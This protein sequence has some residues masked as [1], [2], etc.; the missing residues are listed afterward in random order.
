VDHVRAIH[1]P[2]DST[3]AERTSA[4]TS[5]AGVRHGVDILNHV[6]WIA[7][8]AVALGHLRNILLVEYQQVAHPGLFTRLFY[9]LTGFGHF[10]VI[11]FFVLSGYLVGGKVLSLLHTRDIDREWR[12]FLVDRFARIF[13]VLVPALLLSGLV[14]LCAASVFDSQL[15]LVD[16]W[17]RG[18]VAPIPHDLHAP[19]WIGNLLLLNGIFV[20]TVNVD[21]ALW[22]LAYEWFYYMAAA[23][24]VVVYRRLWRPHTI[25]F[26]LYVLVLAAGVVV[27][28]PNVLIAGGSWVAGVVARHIADRGYLQ[29]RSVWIAGMISVVIAIVA[30]RSYPHI[31]DPVL[32][33]CIAFALCHSRW[34]TVSLAPDLG[35]RLANFSYT[36]YLIHVPVIAL[37][38]GSVQSA[39]FLQQRMPFDVPGTSIVI[40]SFLAMVAIA[41]LFAAFTEDRTQQL[42]NWILRAVL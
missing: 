40:A 5:N 15:F 12:K 35:H 29:S 33:C 13:I 32:G 3:H 22:S 27:R 20:D 39:G 10:A 14:L 41:R 16:G 23:G 36:L 6:R 42:R 30:F 19:L 24:A 2:V 37:A 38:A 34:S 25:V 8:A 17:S 18:W 28:N 9:F 7:A 26:L 21:G 31:P 4:L 1:E 11:V